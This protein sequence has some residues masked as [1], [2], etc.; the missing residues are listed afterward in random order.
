VWSLW[1]GTRAARGEWERLAQVIRALDL[2]QPSAQ[3][4]ASEWIG[5]LRQRGELAAARDAARD[6][7]RKLRTCG[8]P[9][10]LDIGIA[11]LQAGQHTECAAWLRDWRDRPDA[12]PAALFAL[13]VS[14]RETASDDEALEVVRAGAA[15][16]PHAHTQS[17]RVWLAFEL[18]VR[19]ESREA[20]KWLAEAGDPSENVYLHKVATL[21]EAILS[22]QHAARGQMW[23]AFARA[24]AG[25]ASLQMARPE[26]AAVDVLVRAHARAS[27]RIAHDV[28]FP[29]GP[30]WTHGTTIGLVALMLGIG[31]LLIVAFA[32][33]AA[34]G[35]HVPVGSL[36]FGLIFLFRYLARKPRS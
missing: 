15:H 11:L 3:A 18:A 17:H 9:L 1:I 21:T 2:A 26:N 4:A 24:R 12:S 33:G 20:S 35:G 27:R 5:A 31:A 34:E 25:L 13:A 30:L 16:A 32:S 19:G 22:V 14:L 36:F 8:D 23:G 29:L 7:R 6:L 28:G 10:W